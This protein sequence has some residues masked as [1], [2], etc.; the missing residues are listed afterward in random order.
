MTFTQ[1]ISSSFQK[2][3]TFSGRAS[4]S[5]FWF[6]YLFYMIVYVILSI[7]IFG[8]QYSLQGDIDDFDNRLPTFIMTCALGIPLWTLGV[9]RLLDVGKSGW[10]YL[11]SLTG[12]GAFY[13]LYLLCSR[14]E[15]NTNM[16]GGQQMLQSVTQFQSPDPHQTS[17]LASPSSGP[18]I[19]NFDK[20]EWNSM[21]MYNNTFAKCSELLAPFGDDA[22]A[23][24]MRIYK[25]VNNESKAIQIATDI[26]AKFNNDIMWFAKL[27]VK[28]IY[29]GIDVRVDENSFCFFINGKRINILDFASVEPAIDHHL[30]SANISEP[31]NGS[32]SEAIVKHEASDDIEFYIPSE[33]VNRVIKL[34]ERVI[35]AVDGV[36]YCALIPLVDINKLDG[37][38]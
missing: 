10:W 37:I 27:P 30:K 25:I 3:F 36:P 14:S 15:P 12:I 11:I 29:R 16:Y 6:F 28:H 20:V 7:V 17:H 32:F 8:L 33:L 24:F 2:Y 23:E 26:S 21:V 1:A 35:L 9:R 38:A 19:V 22:V 34:D 5:E 18:A 13:I 31:G 4:R